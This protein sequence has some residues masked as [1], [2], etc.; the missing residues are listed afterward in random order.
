MR[1]TPHKLCLLC[2][3]RYATKRNSHIFPK[4]WVKSI[5]GDDNQREA[6]TVSSSADK[7]GQK[8]QDSPKED[9]ILCP[10]CEA[11]FGILERYVANN[12]Y[13][14]FKNFNTSSD[15]TEIKSDDDD[16]DKIFAIKVDPILFKLFI[17]SFVWRASIAT[18]TVFVNFKLTT[19]DEENLRLTLDSYVMNTER[20]TIEYYAQ[21][22]SEFVCLPFNIITTSVIPDTTANL[23][24]PFNL[25]DGR[26]LLFANEFII[27][28]YLDWEAPNQGNDSFNLGRQLLCISVLPLNK[29]QEYH[30]MMVQ[31]LVKHRGHNFKKN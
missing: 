19:Q 28:M 30:A 12:F 16:I 29:W 2:K 11:K 8:V 20:D 23:I 7:L 4:F 18:H 27:T 9:Y 14:P 15:F 26:L 21:N 1:R 22:Q 25:D 10:E 3:V 17:Y 13:N 31:M 5:L 24:S 6:Y